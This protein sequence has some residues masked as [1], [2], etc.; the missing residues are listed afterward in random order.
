MKDSNF[1]PR[2]GRLE[3]QLRFQRWTIGGLLIAVLTIVG[4][5]ASSSDVA[6]ELKAKKLVIV[7]DKGE[8]VVLLMS[9]K[10]GGVAAIFGP[11]GRVPVLIAGGRENGG[12]L[13][14]KANSGQNRVELL[15][16]T[17]RGKVSV[18]SNGQMQQLG[19]PSPK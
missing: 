17:D 19:M 15:G 12:E 16:D 9:E 7:N 1:E 4:I 8:Q 14:I 11:G 10:D 3:R 13:L 18:S 6:N 5:G 2:I